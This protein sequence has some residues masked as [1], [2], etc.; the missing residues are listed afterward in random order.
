[1]EQER[2]ELI[3]T[4]P[5]ILHA[6]RLANPLDPLKKSISEFTK[7][8]TK[9]DEDWAE[10]FRME[11]E[12]GMY[13]SD[14][15]GPIIPAFVLLAMIRSA[16]KLTKRGR[17]IQRG[18][19]ILETETPIEYNGPRVLQKMWDSGDYADIRSVVVQNQRIMRCRPIF[20]SWGLKF[21]IIVNTEILDLAEVLDIIKTGGV[22]EGLCENRGAGFGRFNIVS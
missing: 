2:I 14:E 22:I 4:S 1:M 16:A 11:W 10:I 7:K 20:K 8:R 13:F 9:T 21:N 18:V 3:G 19:M 12:G 17:H 5:L 15:K 6:D